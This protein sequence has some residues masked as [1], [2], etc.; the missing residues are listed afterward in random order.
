MSATP[1][2]QANL[3]W[4]AAYAAVL[5]AQ[6]AAT[7]AAPVLADDAIAQIA[8]DIACA[9][10]ERRAEIEEADVVTID[11]IEHLVNIEVTRAQQGPTYGPITSAIDAFLQEL[12]GGEGQETTL[13]QADAYLRANGIDPERIG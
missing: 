13:E 12:Q 5:V 10:Y 11:L 7:S 1:Q 9:M 2:D 8:A 4:T 3:T 6:Q